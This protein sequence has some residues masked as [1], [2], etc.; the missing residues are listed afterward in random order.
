M[1]EMACK[2]CKDEFCVNG[3]CPMR[4]DYCPVPNISGVC[5]YENRVEANRTPK[6][7]L[8]IILDDNGFAPQDQE[9]SKVWDE[10][11][12]L[13]AEN[14]YIIADINSVEFK[15]KS[16]EEIQAKVE[17][18][19]N[20]NTD[21]CAD[22]PQKYERSTADADK[23]VAKSERKTFHVGQTVNINEIANSHDWVF[24]RKVGDGRDGHETIIYVS[25]NRCMAVCF[26][27]DCD[28]TIMLNREKH[29]ES[30]TVGQRVHVGDIGA[31]KDWKFAGEIN[32]DTA[33]YESIDGTMSVA[34]VNRS[35]WATIMRLK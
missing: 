27:D 1:K 20:K 24:E 13:V 25:R 5:K 15:P 2:Y 35:D 26:Y 16:L 8:K 3:D 14:G 32:S 11:V 19:D 21:V 28:G 34:F 9:M 17:E 4:G 31:S 33:Y 6:D 7:C 18:V 10:F 23:N 30:F 29:D 12:E 22:K